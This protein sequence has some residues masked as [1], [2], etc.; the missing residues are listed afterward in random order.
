M[1]KREKEILEKALVLLRKHLDPDSIILFGSRAKKEKRGRSDFDIAVDKR[2]PSA[3]KLRSLKEEINREAGLYKVDLIFLKS[4]EKDFREIVLKT[5]RV[6]YE[7][8]K[9]K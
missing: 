1:D 7:R 9:G 4:V 2:K 5:G 6:L 3:E 8:K